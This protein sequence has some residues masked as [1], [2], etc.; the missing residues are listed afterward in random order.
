MRGWATSNRLLCLLPGVEDRAV[1]IAL[2][3]GVVSPFYEDFG[4]LNE[5]GGQESGEGADEDFLE[6]RGVQPFSNS[7]DSASSQGLYKLLRNLRS[8]RELQNFR[9]WLMPPSLNRRKSTPIIYRDC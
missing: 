8:A 4:P 5:R 9:P 1:L 6:E 2:V 7:S 3:Q